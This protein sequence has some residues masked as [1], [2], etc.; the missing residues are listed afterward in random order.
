MDRD[1]NFVFLDVETLPAEKDAPLWKRLSAPIQP[2]SGE[3][4]EAFEARLELIRKNT[5]MNPALGR[6]WMIGVAY[7]SEDPVILS[8]DGSP[9]AEADILQRLSS[10][11]NANS[12]LVGYNIESFDIPFLKVRCLHH[13]KPRIAALL[14]KH[15][16][17]PWDARITDLMKVWPRTGADKA[18][19][20][21]DLRGLG[22][23]D[24][25]CEVLGISRQTGVM[26]PE[27]ADAYARGDRAGVEEHLRLDI[28]QTRDVFRAL[29]PII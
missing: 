12:W 16:T 24:T 21:S 23:L 28:I 3:T 1:A 25:V 4:P 22:K 6:V 15:T 20:E 18:A 27:V 2:K 26:G 7:R 5:A 14:G 19:W 9:E 17:K 8:G 10:H 13:K 29:Y 11:I